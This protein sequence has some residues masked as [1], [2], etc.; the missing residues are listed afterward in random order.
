[1][2]IEN[3]AEREQALQRELE[4]ARGQIRHLEKRLF[5]RKSEHHWAIDNQ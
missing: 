1:M 5:G 3:E 4:Y 2:E